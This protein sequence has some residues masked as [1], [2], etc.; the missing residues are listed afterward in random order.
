MLIFDTKSQTNIWVIKLKSAS[1]PSSWIPTKPMF[2]QSFNVISHKGKLVTP[3]M[4][5]I[6]PWINTSLM[7]VI[8]IEPEPANSTIMHYCLV[9]MG[10][11]PR[12]LKFWSNMTKI[13][14]IPHPIVSHWF[15]RHDSYVAPPRYHLVKKEE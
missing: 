14:V 12:T 13:A 15:C 3:Q 6:V 7:Q 10:N 8:K 11:K 2:L 5:K 9:Q 4:I 1:L